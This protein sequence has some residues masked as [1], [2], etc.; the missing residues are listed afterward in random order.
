MLQKRTQV[1]LVDIEISDSVGGV[2]GAYNSSVSFTLSIFF[3]NSNSVTEQVVLWAEVG[4]DVTIIDS[5]FAYHFGFAMIF[6]HDNQSSANIYRSC[7]HHNTATGV[8]IA[9]DHVTININQSTFWNN[10]ANEG[11]V[12][13]AQDHVNININ[14][15]A[16]WNNTANE[17]RSFVCTR[18]CIYQH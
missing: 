7:F 10:T 11:G 14:Q 3:N 2:M 18:P 5:E 8:L 4:S 17:E 13:C 6:V 16:F 12:L 1:V 9:R 15:S